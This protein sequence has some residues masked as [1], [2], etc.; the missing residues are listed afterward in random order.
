VCLSGGPILAHSPG[1][2]ETLRRDGCIL[3]NR[4]R[5]WQVEIVAQY[6]EQ[7]LSHDI[8]YM[9]SSESGDIRKIL[10]SAAVTGL[11]CWTGLSGGSREGGSLECAV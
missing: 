3:G 2:P 8:R 7:G 9:F 10:T 4:A 5:R 11:P 6:P 1:S